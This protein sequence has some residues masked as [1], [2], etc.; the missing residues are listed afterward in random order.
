MQFGSQLIQAVDDNGVPIVDK[1]KFSELV[2]KKFDISTADI[3]DAMLSTDEYL[4]KVNEALQIQQAIQLMQM[5]YAPQ[6]IVPEPQVVEP[7]P[8]VMPVEPQPMPMEMAINPEQIVVE[9]QPTLN[10]EE[11]ALLQGV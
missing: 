3:N 11:I 8:E 1:K 5:Q 6:Q 2:L 4:A 10:E 9:Q 7:Q